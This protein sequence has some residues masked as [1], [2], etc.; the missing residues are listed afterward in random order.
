MKFK[1]II[2][3]GV[4]SLGL[5]VG[6]SSFAGAQGG[7]ID[8]TGYQSHNVVSK[9]TS[10]KVSVDNDNWL[11][12]H[13]G[14]SQS[15]S[16]GEVGVYH[17]TTVGS[18]STGDSSN[19]NSLNASIAV[20]NSASSAAVMPSTSSSSDASGSIST[21]GA[22]SHNVVSSVDTTHVYV[23]NDNALKV[24]NN[25][26]QTATSGDATVAGNTTVG[27]VSTGN[28]TNTNSTTIS[29]KVSN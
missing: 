14:N 6:L 3:A 19:T 22:D 4:M 15:A 21:T 1:K 5:V 7:S 12:A 29:F 27:S 20:D 10:H 11:S 26:C 18:A 17:N 2:S 8:H 13:N 23:D 16:S 24:D 25:N 9:Y 28:A